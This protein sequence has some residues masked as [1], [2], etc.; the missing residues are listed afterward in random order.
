MVT[1][2]MAAE[3]EAHATITETEVVEVPPVPEVLA[4][5]EELAMAVEAEVSA[6]M[7]KG[8]SGA[9][10]SHANQGGG[11][12]SEQFLRHCRRPFEPA[13]GDHRLLSS[14]LQRRE[15]TP[16]IVRRRR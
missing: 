1:E 5:A 7:C 14:Q 15:D 4:V 3:A 8:R 13:G 16:H 12:Q 6:A 11:G 9:Y 2:T 10:Q